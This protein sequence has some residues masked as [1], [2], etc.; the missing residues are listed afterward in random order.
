MEWNNV[1]FKKQLCKIQN[2]EWN[3]YLNVIADLVFDV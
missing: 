2:T 1:H 3:E